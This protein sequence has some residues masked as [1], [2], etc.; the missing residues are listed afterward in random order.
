MQAA[1]TAKLPILTYHSIDSSGSVISVAP[2]VFRWQMKSLNKAGYNVVS[3]NNLVDSLIDEK[4]LIAKTVALTFDDGFRNFY[5]AAFPVLEEYGFKATVYLVTDYCGKRNEWE[6]A[7]PNI[8]LSDLLN[9]NEI[10]KLNDYGIEFG[11]HTLTHPDLTRI[12]IAQAKREIFE[13][14]AKIEDEIGSAVKSFA[15][16]YGK[17]N[18]SVRSIAAENFRAACSTNLGKARRKSD[19]YS[20]ERIDAYYLSNARIFNSLSS[21][22]LDSYLQLRQ[23]L[24]TAKKLV[25]GN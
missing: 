6:A 15:Y 4:P 10:R 7:S 22:G 24:R 12:T 8:P 3:L 13:S 9:W 20:L 19:F 2:E 21:T 14:K 25:G 23:W 5:T 17:F 16:P 18:D 1:E 11:A